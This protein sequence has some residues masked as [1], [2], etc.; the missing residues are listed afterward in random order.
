M[1]WPVLPA[2]AGDGSRS[3]SSSGL[4]APSDVLAALA[5]DE[6]V[7][8]VGKPTR[9]PFFEPLDLVIGLGGVV[10]AGLMI[11][12][13]LDLSAADSSTNLLFV[14]VFLVGLYLTIGRVAVRTW[15][16]LSSTYVLTTRRAFISI[17]SP[18]SLTREFDISRATMLEVRA[19]PDG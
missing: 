6:E 19:R 2:S 9:H 10:W 18:R 11:K 12:S 3:L 5:A 13:L 15:Q 14:V 17:R 1:T 4:V 16:R 8:W 7:V